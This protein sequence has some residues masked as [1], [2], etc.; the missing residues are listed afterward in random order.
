MEPR[1]KYAIDMVMDAFDDAV[2]NVPGATREERIVALV[3]ELLPKLIDR[4]SKAGALDENH[5][6]DSAQKAAFM[7][8]LRKSIEETKDCVAAALV[9]I[10]HGGRVLVAGASTGLKD[11]FIPELGRRLKAATY[12]FALDTTN[13]DACGCPACVARRSSFSPDAIVQMPFTGPK[14]EA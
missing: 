12:G 11:E 2:L 13:V 6:L 1:L 3:D 5:D 9:R 4:S 10:T 8:L 14:A 7:L